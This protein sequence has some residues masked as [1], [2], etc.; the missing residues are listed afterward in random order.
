MISRTGTF[1]VKDCRTEQRARWGRIRWEARVK[2]EREERE[3]TVQRWRERS[4]MKRADKETQW[5]NSAEQAAEVVKALPD[6]DHEVEEMAMSGIKQNESHNSKDN[7]ETLRR[8][9]SAPWASVFDGSG[10]SAPFDAA[11]RTDSKD[12]DNDDDTHAFAATVE[13]EAYEEVFVEGEGDNGGGEEKIVEALQS[14][15]KAFKDGVAVPVKNLMGLRGARAAP[16][17]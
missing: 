15:L 17:L 7:H 10:G 12:Y 8:S 2:R 5:L 6:R 4:R 16:P 3:Q 11:W 13:P 14:E 9:S 1:T